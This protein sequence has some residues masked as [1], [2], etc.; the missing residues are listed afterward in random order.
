ML[1]FNLYF[2][3]SQS[4]RLYVRNLPYVCTEEDLEKEFGKYGESL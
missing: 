1:G 2:C 4:G 3:L